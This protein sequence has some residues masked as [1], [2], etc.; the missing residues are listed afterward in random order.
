MDAESGV[1][2]V[3]TLEALEAFYREIA[4]TTRQLDEIHRTRLRCSRG[5]SSC[6][7]DDLS[8]YEIEAENIR[9][10]HAE[11]LASATPHPPGACA[12]LD[13]AGACRVYPQRP[14]VCRTQG[15][16]L[17]WLAAGPDGDPVEWRDICPINEDERPIVELLPQDCW[18]IGP[19]E[20]RLAQLQL[21]S[22]T[23][24]MHRIRLRTLF[25]SSES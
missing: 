18:T 12:F 2:Q 4:D 5:C 19:A 15:Y 24:R 1:E 23:H 25:A 11:L 21:A 20:E 13:H 7:V 10:H 14:Y 6:C 22:A 16:P 3:A 8:V 17:R 9:R